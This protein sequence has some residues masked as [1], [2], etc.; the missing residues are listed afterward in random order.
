MNK[1]CT[2]YSTLNIICL[3][4]CVL[5]DSE[6]IMG[7]F[8]VPDNSFQSFSVAS[9]MLTTGDNVADSYVNSIVRHDIA[10]RSDLQ[11]FVMTS[12]AATVLPFQS[13]NLHVLRNTFSP[14]VNYY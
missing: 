9:V 10:S 13:E 11:N 6:A 7:Y 12:C 1:L 5:L 8:L 3:V 14:K 4:S 2:Y